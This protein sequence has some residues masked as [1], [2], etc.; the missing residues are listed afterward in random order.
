MKLNFQTYLILKRKIIKKKRNGNEKSESN[1]M[2]LLNLWLRYDIRI[3]LYKEK[4][5]KQRIPISN[6]PNDDGWN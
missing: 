3:T 1:L 5:K 6:K 4:V 2:D